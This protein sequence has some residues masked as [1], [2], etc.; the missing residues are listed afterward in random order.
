MT[1]ANS[2]TLIPAWSGKYDIGIF[3]GSNNDYTMDSASTYPQLLFFRIIHEP[4]FAEK[5]LDLQG[6]TIAC[7]CENIKTCHGQ[8]LI[9]AVDYINEHGGPEAVR[10]ITAPPFRDVH[11][12]QVKDERSGR[13][14]TNPLAGQMMNK[15]HPRVAGWEMTPAEELIEAPF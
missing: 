8:K 10:Q 6:K 3:R 2:I 13:M 11:P 1:S 12:M 4:G 15:P 5:L 9:G 14:V 7:M